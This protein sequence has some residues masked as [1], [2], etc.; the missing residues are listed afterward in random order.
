M[1]VSQAE[2][3]IAS[4]LFPTQDIYVLYLFYLFITVK[5]YIKIYY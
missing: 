4:P 2:Q 5:N 1:S 3:F